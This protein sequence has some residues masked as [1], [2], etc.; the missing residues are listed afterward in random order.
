MSKMLGKVLIGLRD[1][2]EDVSY[3]LKNT[4]FKVKDTV[5]EVVNNTKNY[6]KVAMIDAELDD[7]F[8]CLGLTVFEEGLTPENENATALIDYM[9]EKYKEMNELKKEMGI[10]DYCDDCD[11]CDN[12]DDCYKDCEKD[13]PF[14]D[15]KETEK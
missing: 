6:A 5:K 11:G 13:Y 14:D 4:D 1:M 15:V 2:G 9:T 8:Y 10:F 7:L 12:C 3:A